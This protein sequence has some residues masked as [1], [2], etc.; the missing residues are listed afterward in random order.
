MASMGWNNSFTNWYWKKKILKECKKDHNRFWKRILRM[1]FQPVK[2]GWGIR[3]YLWLRFLGRSCR[4]SGRFAWFSSCVC[5]SRRR[6]PRR[7][8]CWSAAVAAV[9]PGD[10]QGDEIALLVRPRA[11]VPQPTLHLPPLQS[12]DDTCSTTA[13]RTK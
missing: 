5:I 4:G 7:R 12:C 13:N 6:P 1:S 2:I 9:V 8:C 11:P 10:Q 3:L